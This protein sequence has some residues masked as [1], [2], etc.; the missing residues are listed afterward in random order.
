MALQEEL[1]K[2]GNWLFKYRSF[3]PLIILLIG[4]ILYLRTELYPETFFLEETPYEIYFE[5][6][7][8]FKEKI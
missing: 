3:L 5:R 7:C 8:L 6:L 1:E 2:Q 4:T